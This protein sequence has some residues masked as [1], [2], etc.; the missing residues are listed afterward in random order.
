MKKIL[1]IS[2]LLLLSFLQFSCST[3][4]ITNSSPTINPVDVY[5]AGSK[6]GQACYWK[7]GQIVML[8]SGGFIATEA[9]KI[10]VSNGDIY[11]FGQTKNTSTSF[12][13]IL[14]LY[15]KNEVLTNLNASLSTN[16]QIVSSISDMDVVG[17]DVYFVGSINPEII[18]IFTPILVYWKN[19]AITTANAY[20]N[21]HNEMSKIKVLNNDV[22]ITAAG[23]INNPNSA[24]N[25]YYKNLEFTEILPFGNLKGF[26]VNNNSIF[27]YGSQ[28]LRG[29]HFNITTNTNTT[30]NFPNDGGILN[31]FFDNNNIYYSNGAT[32]YKNGSIYNTSQAITQISDFRVLNDNLYKINTS[33]FGAP[34]DIQTVSI[35]NIITLTSSNGESFNTLFIDQN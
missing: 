4:G 20:N 21:G 35:N 28:L 29:F 26:E 5:V 30:V 19:N 23:K 7:N 13:P 15:W 25:G 18:T 9:K 27:T 3:E 8:D 33:S 10:I 16:S 32:I 24:I 34:I 12:N 17:N 14:A 6:D 1:F 22:Y 31:M 11:V 2:T